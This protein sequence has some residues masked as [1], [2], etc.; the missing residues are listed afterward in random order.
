MILKSNQLKIS[1]EN[2]F[3]S[4]CATTCTEILRKSD[5]ITNTYYYEYNLPKIEVVNRDLCPNTMYLVDKISYFGVQNPDKLTSELL[6]VGSNYDMS[7]IYDEDVQ[8]IN[9]VDSYGN[10]ML[11]YP[12]LYD[13]DNYVINKQ[14]WFK[15]ISR[16]PLTTLLVIDY[17][18][19]IQT[20]R[21]KD[22]IVEYIQNF[23]DLTYNLD[24]L[25]IIFHRGNSIS[26][27]NHIDID[28]I[29]HDHINRIFE[30]LDQVPF[31]S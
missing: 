6:C 21:L 25:G 10:G 16:S 29:T 3:L 22:S 5:Y 18:A 30:L 23:I 7:D 11:T 19:T 4:R 13:P 8:S 31:G 24:K 26:D 2:S 28:Y 20:D 15:Y 17:T 14:E 27:I 1:I 12:A 9:I